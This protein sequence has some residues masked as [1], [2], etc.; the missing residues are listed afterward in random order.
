MANE[1]TQVIRETT[2]G[3]VTAL[4]GTFTMVVRLYQYYRDHEA[5]PRMQC[6]QGIHTLNPWMKHSNSVLCII[7]GLV[8]HRRS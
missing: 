3:I 5:N 4:L 7:L 8:R 1:S 2:K 6:V